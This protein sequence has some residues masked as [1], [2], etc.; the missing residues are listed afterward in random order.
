MH[1]QDTR[2]DNNRT[3]RMGDQSKLVGQPLS[4]MEHPPV[5][6]EAGNEKFASLSFPHE[7]PS[8]VNAADARAGDQRAA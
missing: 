1:G 3:A 7:D 6:I 5:C 8:C 4:C 2:L